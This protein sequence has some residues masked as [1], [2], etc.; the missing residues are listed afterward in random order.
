M[1]LLII[2][3][4][5]ENL[6]QSL[7]KYIEILSMIISKNISEFMQNQDPLLILKT[8]PVL[9]DFVKNLYKYKECLS[10]E[11]IKEVLIQHVYLLKS[12]Y[13]MIEEEEKVK[14]LNVMI[15]ELKKEFE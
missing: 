7:E 9:E 12:L 13:K 10:V 2:S 5:E 15:E 14:K 11:E 8:I 4:L 6:P 1:E 3:Q